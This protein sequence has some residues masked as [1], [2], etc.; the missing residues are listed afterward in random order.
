MRRSS[1]FWS[2][3]AVVA[4]AASA[5][6]LLMM[7]LVDGISMGPVFP[8]GRR[9]LVV[10]IPSLVC[11]GCVLVFRAPVAEDRVPE[12]ALLVKRVLAVAG[13]EV[14]A[15]L[16]TGRLAGAVRVPSG[17]LLVAGDGPRSLDGRQ[18]GFTPRTAVVGLVIAA[19]D[20]AGAIDAGG[21]AASRV[22]TSRSQAAPGC[23]ADAASQQG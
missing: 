8:P 20:L 12:H 6:R 2:A 17:H 4:T 23:R 14:P 9:L 1:A 16:R 15:G 5:R 18:L 3:V 7:V 11:R 21:A 10:R 22:L 19:A 13:D